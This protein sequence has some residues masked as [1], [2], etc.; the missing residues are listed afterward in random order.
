[1]AAVTT[2]LGTG[3][4]GSPGL[5]DGGPAVAATVGSPIGV[6]VATN[7]D[8]Y[9]A[10]WWHNL[11]RK[12]TATTG[13][14]STVVGGGAGLPGTP[15]ATAALYDPRGL[16]IDS[17]GQLYIA[18]GNYGAVFRVTLGG[19]LEIAAGDGTNSQWTPLDGNLA[20]AAHLNLPQA[21]AFDSG[22]D[23]YIADQGRVRRVNSTTGIISTYVGTGALGYTGDNGLATAATIQ[24]PG[25]IAF[26]ADDNLYITDIVYAVV[27]RVDRATGII[28]TVL[29]GASTTYT[30][31]G[32][33]ATAATAVDCSGLVI[34]S[35]GNIYFGDRWAIRRIDAV[36][37]I[38][39][40]FVGQGTSDP[41][42]TSNSDNGFDALDAG[43]YQPGG[44]AISPSN[45]LIY[46][47]EGNN[48]VRKVPLGTPV[49]CCYG[50][51][52]DLVETIRPMLN[53]SLAPYRHSDPTM[54]QWLSD[55]QRVIAQLVPEA[56][57][58]TIEF[59]PEVG[60]TRQRLDMGDAHTLIRVEQNR[61]SVTVPSVSEFDGAAIP[62][63]D[64]DVYDTFDPDWMS[65]TPDPT[66]EA[67]YYFDGFCLDPNDPLGFFLHPKPTSTRDRVYVTY[68]AVPGEITDLTDCMELPSMYHGA[69]VNYVI[70]RAASA[71]TPGYAPAA[72]A[73]AI[74]RFGQQLNLPRDTILGLIGAPHRQMEQQQ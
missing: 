72:A 30:G 24:L 14:V 21:I 48:M 46:S 36:T 12:I 67:G 29:G 50:S 51:A 71:Q 1:M 62:V 56:L 73:R 49:T 6:A 42:G 52:G 69:L 32:G 35:T 17:L 68:G 39:T 28:T 44:L 65:R 5:G 25:Q 20:T 40:R 66:P 9:V 60:T 61:A 63:V 18:D 59:T 70:Y 11:V 37:G 74:E 26:D 16:A 2:I 54:L 31:D 38:V 34:D 53:D 10:E 19:I 58:V 22:G 3:A 43:V 33:L 64:R 55:G 7:G 45:D 27:R 4:I 47:S 15:A 41:F 8:I 23:M 57:P 13:V